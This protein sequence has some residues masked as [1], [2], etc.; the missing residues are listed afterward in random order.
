MEIKFNPFTKKPQY[1]QSSNGDIGGKYGINM[2]TLTGAKMLTPNED[3]VY[4]YLN[5]ND[6]NRVIM[7]DTANAKAGDRFVIKN[8][9]DWNDISYLEVKVEDTTYDKIYTGIFKTWIFDGTEWLDAWTGTGYGDISDS[10]EM[11]R[12]T[13]IGR[14]TQDKECG[15]AIGKNANAVL[16]AVAIGC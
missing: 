10:R 7:L 6:T 12:G 16:D 4:Q 8:N 5:P 3:Y 1:I 13:G 2:E 15:V 14:N 11:Y 9:G